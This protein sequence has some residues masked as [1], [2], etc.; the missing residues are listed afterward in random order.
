MIDERWKVVESGD[1]EYQEDTAIF[2]LNGQEVVGCSEW[3]RVDDGVFEH[4]CALH[5]EWLERQV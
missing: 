5:N 3:M 1:A 4:I 2:T